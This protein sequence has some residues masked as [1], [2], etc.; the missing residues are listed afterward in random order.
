MQTGAATPQSSSVRHSTHSPP[1]T[2]H[3]R[4]SSQSA[5]EA[6]PVHSPSST[7]HTGKLP[8]HPTVAVHSTHS[9]AAEHAGVAGGHPLTLLDVHS[10]QAPVFAHASPP[11][12][13]SAEQATQETPSQIGVTPPQSFAP[14]HAVQAGAPSSSVHARSSHVW[15][16]PSSQ[17]SAPSSHTQRPLAASQVGVL[18]AHGCAVHAPSV[19]T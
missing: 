2:S 14:V 1:S 12:Q 6:H 13:L 19:H 15:R 3:T 10:T 16:T 7:S 18:P 17:R 9:F 8:E 4:S 5:S 11:G